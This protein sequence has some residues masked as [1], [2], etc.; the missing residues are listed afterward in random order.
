MSDRWSDIHGPEGPAATGFTGRQEGRKDTPRVDD[1]VC[2]RDCT[3]RHDRD[4]VLRCPHC[5]GVAYELWMHTYRVNPDVNFL[6]RRP[7]AG[8]PPLAADET[9]PCCRDCGCRLVRR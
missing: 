7:V 8:A 1:P 9:N 3:G 5:G 2:P 4:S 6:E